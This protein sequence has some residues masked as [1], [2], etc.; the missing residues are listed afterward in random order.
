[1]TNS[2]TLGGTTWTIVDK[3][4]WL[5][6][7]PS[8]FSKF[9]LFA[10]IFVLECFLTYVLQLQFSYFRRFSIIFVLGKFI[11]HV[12]KSFVSNFFLA[13]TL[14]DVFNSL[15]CCLFSQFIFTRFSIEITMALHV[16]CC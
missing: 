6:L 2:K 10:I 9:C 14:A 5:F 4:Q 12:H 11:K 8:Q 13:S 1:M 16:F 7:L 3:S 15:I